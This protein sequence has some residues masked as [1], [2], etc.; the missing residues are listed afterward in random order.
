MGIYIRTSVAN[1]GTYRKMASRAV[2]ASALIV[3]MGGCVNNDYSDLNSYIKSVKAR[4]AGRI[5]PVPEFKT[6]ET[7]TYSAADLRDPFEAFNNEAT[8]VEESETGEGD[9]LRPNRDRN[10][11]T[12][13]EYPLDTLNFVG[14]L[15]KS[16]EKWAIITSPDDLVHRVKIGNHLGTNYGEIVAISETKI[17]VREIIQDGMGGWIE[18]EAAL[19][20]SE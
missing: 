1:V 12:L 5:D 3:A 17:A 19:S 10:K 4:P 20:L 6:Y 18:R 7:Y 2:V 8:V 13:E 15:E 16:G 9:G 11:E 14:H